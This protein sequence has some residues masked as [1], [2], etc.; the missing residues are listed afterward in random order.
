MTSTEVAPSVLNRA[1]WA[2]YVSFITN[3]FLWGAF[4]PRFPE[5]KSLFH[6][7]NSQFGLALLVGSIGILLAMKP[8]GTIVGR[9]GSA[10]TLQ[11]TTALFGAS[12][13]ATG[14]LLS[15]PYFVVTLFI[16]GVLIA[17]HDIAMNSQAALIERVSAKSLM[18]GFHARFS[19]GALLGAAFGATCAQL[20]VPILTE[21]IF[22]VTL[23]WL[24][25][26]F[27]RSALLDKSFEPQDEPREPGEHRERPHIFWW[28][29]ILGFCAS[30]CEGA[31]SDW[32]AVLLRDTWH[33]AP[34]IAGLP[35][36]MFSATMVIGRFSGDRVTD[37]FSREWVVRWGGFTAGSGL[38]VGLL[39]GGAVGVT[40]G[41]TL[42]GLGVSIAIPSIFSA[43]GEIASNR[44]VGHVSP[45]QAV[46]IVGG[47]SYAGFLIGPPLIGML[48]DVLSL[49]WAMLVPAI[50]ALIM[51]SVA[52]IARA[53]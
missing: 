22:V 45:A 21:M 11:I 40:V 46:A 6:L 29:G 9:Y 49:R 48:A 8:S 30:V 13:I 16:V 24:T 41:W 50:L 39:I 19:F 20:D 28:L 12:M 4:V 27:L 36:V 47:V 14:F 33:V 2:V 44:F 51:G 31:A 37:T 43:A 25:I 35:Y 32:G 3:G 10:R 42:L 26:P 52:R 7:T 17:T 15:V 1:R 53:Q 34:F 23:A 5:V 18:N 38:I